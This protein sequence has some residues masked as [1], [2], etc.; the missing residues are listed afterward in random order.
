ML[1]IHYFFR[2]NSIFEE[3]PQTTNAEI[4]YMS[5]DR[6]ST[7]VQFLEKRTHY[8]PKISIICGSGLGK[9][10]VVMLLTIKNFQVYI[11]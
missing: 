4:D 9:F 1:Y 8:R 5:F 2:R 3:I 10:I 11:D 7:T 6:I